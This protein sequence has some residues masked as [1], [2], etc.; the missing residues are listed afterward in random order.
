LVSGVG[1]RVERTSEVFL[2]VEQLSHS[3][4]ELIDIEV[5]ANVTNDTTTEEVCVNGPVNGSLDGIAVVAAI[6]MMDHRRVVEGWAGADLI[7]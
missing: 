2:G 5:L 1:R 7:G 3:G 6:R 4:E